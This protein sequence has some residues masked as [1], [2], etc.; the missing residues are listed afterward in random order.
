[1]QLNVR[2]GDGVAKI[3]PVSPTLG[4]GRGRSFGSGRE[5]SVGPQV[6]HWAS[7]YSN[8]PLRRTVH[9]NYNRG[10]TTQSPNGRAD[11]MPLLRDEHRRYFAQVRVQPNV[12]SGWLSR[13]S[14]KEALLRSTWSDRRCS[15]GIRR[16][17]CAASWRAMRVGTLRRLAG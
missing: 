8:A 13:K 15:C 14:L 5:L 12:R 4:S 17:H 3:T 9:G 10:N 2:A 16:W 1:M 7:C 6:M 11:W